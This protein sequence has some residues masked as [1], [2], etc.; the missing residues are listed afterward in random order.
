MGM[1]KTGVSLEDV[2]DIANLIACGYGKDPH[3]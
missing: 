2:G 1:G 3:N